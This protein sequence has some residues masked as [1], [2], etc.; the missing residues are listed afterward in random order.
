MTMSQQAYG[1]APNS[2]SNSTGD[3]GH[4]RFNNFNTGGRTHGEII[5]GLLTPVQNTPEWLAAW[6]ARQ[7]RASQNALPQLEPGRL[8]FLMG[9]PMSAGG[10][11]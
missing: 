2:I 6:N 7:R 11:G 5:N 1:G 9:N 8:N 10:R 3:S 4:T